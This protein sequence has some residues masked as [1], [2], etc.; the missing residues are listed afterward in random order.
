[1]IGYATLGTNN[2]EQARSFYD[3]LFNIIGAKRSGESDRH[4]LWQVPSGGPKLGVY[5]PFDGHPATAGNG[6][7]VGIH[8]ETKEMVDAL[9]AKALE[10]GATDEGN[11]LRVD[12]KYYMGYFR[13]LDGNKLNFFTVV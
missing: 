3:N 10:L 7:M 5:I 2:L 6:S 13:D 8:V 4:T 11:G 12:G 1:M 9:H